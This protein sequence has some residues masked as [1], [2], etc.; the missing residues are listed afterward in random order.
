MKF[1]IKFMLSA[2]ATESAAIFGQIPWFFCTQF[3][4]TYSGE[5]RLRV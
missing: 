5:F 1:M 3:F 4:A 2:D